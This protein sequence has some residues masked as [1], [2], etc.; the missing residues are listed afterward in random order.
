MMDFEDGYEWSKEAKEALFLLII[1]AVVIV[2]AVVVESF[3]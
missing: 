3:F 1:I 2:V